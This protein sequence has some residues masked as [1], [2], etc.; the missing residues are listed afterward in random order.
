VQVYYI[1]LVMRNLTR[2]SFPKIS[3]LHL[4]GK[5]AYDVYVRAANNECKEA[6]TP[7]SLLSFFE[8]ARTRYGKST[9]NLVKA[10]LRK[11][12]K[13]TVLHD[14]LNLRTG[15]AF[16]TAFSE[17]KISNRDS[18]VSPDVIFSDIEIE[19]LAQ[20]ATPRLACVIRALADTGCRISE[21]VNV[22]LADCN[23]NGR[24]VSVRVTGKGSEERD[25]FLDQKH[26]DLIR[27]VY[28][29]ETFLFETRNGKPLGRKYVWKEMSRLG[30]QVLKRR[31]TPHCAR[32]SFATKQLLEKGRSIK[33]VSRYLGHKSVTTCLKFYIH[34]RLTA[35]EIFASDCK[36]A[37]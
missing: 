22:R 19:R 28:N 16:A 24:I 6:I 29:G 27:S 7:S 25:V 9:L 23:S 26:F 34:D 12:V 36:E 11:S 31:I 18:A 37:I 2:D 35:D 13:L 33:A 15:A 30:R 17:M 21:I 32:H 1:I 4:T 20:C 8:R 3:I 14:S 5:P 10:A